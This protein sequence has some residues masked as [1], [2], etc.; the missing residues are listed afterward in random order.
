M[1]HSM[2]YDGNPSKAGIL[3]SFL[4]R[5]HTLLIISNSGQ[6]LTA[7]LH[8]LGYWSQLNVDFSPLAIDA[9]KKRYQYLQ[10]LEWRVMDVRA[11]VGVGDETF[12]VAIDKVSK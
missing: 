10:G 8:A 7:D 2:A 3:P 9:M 4:P 12:E 1:Q 6:T 5:F 11:M